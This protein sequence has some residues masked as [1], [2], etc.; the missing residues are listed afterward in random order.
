MLPM[1]LRRRRALFIL[2]AAIF[3]LYLLSAQRPGFLSNRRI[4]REKL[5]GY[6][7]PKVDEIY[8][9]IHLVL[10]GDH[11]HHD[12]LSNAVNRLSNYAD[13]KVFDWKDEVQRLNSDYSIV[14]FGEVCWPFYLRM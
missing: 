12:L 11:E 6:F 1:L 10:S 3:A 5:T 9:L 4:S 13:G 2:A 7:G 8:G 14:I